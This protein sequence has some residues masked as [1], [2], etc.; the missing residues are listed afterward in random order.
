MAIKVVELMHAGFRIPPGEGDV[1]KAETLYGKVLGMQLDQERPHIPGIPGFWVNVRNG[2]RQQQIHIMGAEGASPASRSAKQDPTR[3]HVA[4]AVEDLEEA[5]RELEENGIEF[6][7][8]GGLVGPASEQVFF[9][10]GF[11]NMI[12]LQQHRG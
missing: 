7:V 4:L 8:Y 2:S 1:K 3:P 5:K 12:E 11:G 9:E 6:W 10:D